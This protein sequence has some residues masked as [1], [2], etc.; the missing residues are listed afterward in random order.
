MVQP[1]S[2]LWKTTLDLEIVHGLITRVYFKNQQFVNW[3]FSFS[4]VI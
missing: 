2:Y 4:L 1:Y 3:S